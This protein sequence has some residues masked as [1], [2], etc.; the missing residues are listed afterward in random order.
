MTKKHF[1]LRHK[2]ARLNAARFAVE[3]CPDDWM[4]TFSEPNRNAE[5]NARLHA[6]LGDVAAQC[7]WMGKR[8]TAAQWKVLMV[9]GHAVA[10]KE[11]AELVPGLEGEFVN[12]RESTASMS[13]KRCASLITY[14]R[15]WGDMNGVAWTEPAEAIPG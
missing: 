12:I 2:E 7:E 10:T 5:Q 6:M 1:F 4:V 13:I 8:R 3:V 15:A 11:G 9:S 14:I